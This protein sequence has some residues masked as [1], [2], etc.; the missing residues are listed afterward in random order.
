MRQRRRWAQTERQRATAKKID[1][2]PDRQSDP[3]D[4]RKLLF[5]MYVQGPALTQT[6]GITS[7]LII[8]RSKNDGSRFRG[9]SVDR[10]CLSNGTW[11][12]GRIG[13]ERYPDDRPLLIPSHRLPIDCRL[14]SQVFGNSPRGDRHHKGRGFDSNVLKRLYALKRCQSSMPSLLCAGV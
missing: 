1:R 2:H 12:Q 13:C 14:T 8:G 6:N 11:S 4:N 9:K 3:L 5:D 7:I 10:H